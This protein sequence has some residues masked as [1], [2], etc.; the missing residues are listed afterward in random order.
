[1]A[2]MMLL[3][4]PLPLSSSTFRLNSLHFGAMPEMA[5]MFNSL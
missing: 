5:W 2:A 4:R 3:A 1:M